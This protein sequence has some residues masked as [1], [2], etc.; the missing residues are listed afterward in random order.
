MSN[1]EIKTTPYGDQKPGTSG[2]RKR[3]PVFQ[4]PNYVENFVQS[5][6]DCLEVMQG[7]RT[8]RLTHR[9]YEF[10]QANAAEPG[11]K[12][13]VILDHARLRPKQIDVIGFIFE[14]KQ[15]AGHGQDD[16]EHGQ[17]DR[18]GMTVNLENQ[19]VHQSGHRRVRTVPYGDFQAK[20]REHGD[21]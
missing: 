18:A 7:A 1:I 4:Q 2:L 14:S 5:I 21:G 20:R 17:D 3:V 10:N 19:P 15:A 9:Y 16:G 6:F 12:C 13:K 8:Q 11:F